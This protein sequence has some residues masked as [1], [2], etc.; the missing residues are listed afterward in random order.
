M[1]KRPMGDTWSTYILHKEQVTLDCMKHPTETVWH[2]DKSNRDDS[3]RS[4]RTELCRWM[5]TALRAWRIVT[6]WTA[7]CQSRHWTVRQTCHPQ[8]GSHTM[9]RQIQR[10]EAPAGSHLM[11][12]QRHRELYLRPKPGTIWWQDKYFVYLRPK[13][14]AIWWQDKSVSNWTVQSWWWDEDVDKW[15][16][17]RL[18]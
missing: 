9:I 5:W 1:S 13:L 11:T 4:S 2:V 10:F 3:S 6:L 12:G 7:V 18:Y 8:A 16:I 17:Q 15:T 14:E